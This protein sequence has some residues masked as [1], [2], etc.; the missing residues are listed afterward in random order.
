MELPR[1]AAAQADAWVHQARTNKVLG[2]IFTIV[3]VAALLWGFEADNMA[4]MLL[5]IW[6]HIC[7]EAT[8]LW[9][10]GLERSARLLRFLPTPDATPAA[11]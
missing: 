1:T 4:V 3:G 11:S 2:W 10:F 7:G 9:A 8:L 6:A 5:A